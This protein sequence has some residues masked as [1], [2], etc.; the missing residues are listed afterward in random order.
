M[1]Y[2]IFGIASSEQEDRDNEILVLD[3]IDVDNFNFLKDEH[4]DDSFAKIGLIR[5]VKKIYK[6][7]DTKCWREKT[8]WE[9]CKKP[10]LYFEAELL[11]DKKH[12]NAQAAAGLIDA[13][14]AEKIGNIRASIEGGVMTKNNNKLEKTQAHSVVLTIQPVNKDCLVFPYNTL[15]KSNKRYPLNYIAKAKLIKLKMQKSKQDKNKPKN[16]NII[17]KSVLEELKIT[18]DTISEYL[19]ELKKSLYTVE[20]R[21]CKS[22]STFSNFDDDDSPNVCPNCSKHYTMT[23]LKKAFDNKGEAQ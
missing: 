14:A 12:P 23:D 19:T 3:G 1:G 7:Q 17:T 13:L 16:D 4:E 11:D 18:N 15:K 2:K 6:E 5:R 21:F 22:K 9:K 8:C 20:C 10:F